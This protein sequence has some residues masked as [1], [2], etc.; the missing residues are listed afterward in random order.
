MHAFVKH[1]FGKFELASLA[2]Q[3]S[4]ELRNFLPNQ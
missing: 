2:F 3:Q 1:V 4:I